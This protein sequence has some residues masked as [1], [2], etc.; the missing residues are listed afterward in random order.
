VLTVAPA[1]PNELLL[2]SGTVIVLGIFTPEPTTL[3][4]GAPGVGALLVIRRR[5]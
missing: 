5:M 4:L 1:P 2:G 3:A